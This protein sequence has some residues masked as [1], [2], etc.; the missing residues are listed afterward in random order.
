MNLSLNILECSLNNACRVCRLC[1]IT[2][3]G[4]SCSVNLF[5]VYRLMFVA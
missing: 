1:D 4:H 2:Y 3:A 5:T